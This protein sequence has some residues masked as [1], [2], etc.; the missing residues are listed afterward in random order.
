MDPSDLLPL[1]PRDFLI[2]FAL[3][4]EE[5]HGYGIV[6][7]VERESRGQVRLDPANL[8]R[9]IRRMISTGLVEEA[10]RRPA[11]TAGGERRRYYRITQF[12]REVVKREA[13]RL[14]QLTAA[15]RARSLIPGEEAPA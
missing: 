5:R 15:A 6:R 8:Y 10:E 7:D 1:N 13:T 2:L 11:T 14:A 12:G 3:A 4:D 9:S